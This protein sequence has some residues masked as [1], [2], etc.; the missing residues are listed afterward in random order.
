MKM[1]DRF[2]GLN[3]LR[4]R[5]HQRPALPAKYVTTHQFWVIFPKLGPSGGV[6]PAVLGGVNVKM[7]FF[8]KFSLLLTHE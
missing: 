7:T 4:T 8:T 2:L 5:D 1:R 3:A 6:T